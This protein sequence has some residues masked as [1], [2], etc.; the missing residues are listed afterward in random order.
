MRF[1][2]RERSA[3]EVGADDC[4]R[5]DEFMFE[6]RLLTLFI[7]SFVHFVRYCLSFSWPKSDQEI[8]AFTI[9]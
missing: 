2:R 5:N 3:E 1:G 8:G 7:N 6:S 9:A 4:N